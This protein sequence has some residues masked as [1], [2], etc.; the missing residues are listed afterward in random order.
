[1]FF[2]SLIHLWTILFSPMFAKQDKLGEYLKFLE[3]QKQIVNTLGNY[4]AGE[5]EIVTEPKKILEIQ[6]M[7]RIRF[8]N[9]GMSDE[10]AKEASQIGIISKDSYWVWVRDAVVFPTGAAGSYNRLILTS[11]LADGVPGV[12]VLPVLPD[13]KIVLNLHFRHATR[14]WEL[15]VPRG[16]KLMKETIE[17][18]AKRELY[19]ETGLEMSSQEFL[20]FIAPDAGTMSSG[21]PVFL[22]RV[23]KAGISNQDYSEAILRSETFTPTEIKDALGRGW[24][25]T[26]VKGKKERVA[27]RD[28]FLTF[29]LLQAEHKKLL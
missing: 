23:K 27:V 19:E 25:E 21:V 8:K 2:M 14:M 7:Q 22:G 10:E 24:I 15:E 16:F 5:I 17:E 6:E 9:L 18:A 12:A 4:K 3:D 1:M 26:N 28:S 13:G 29:A 11:G 20:G